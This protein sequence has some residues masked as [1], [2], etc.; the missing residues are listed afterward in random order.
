MPNPFHVGRLRAAVDVGGIEQVDSSFQGFV[1]DFKAGRLVGQFAEVHRAES[2]S[3]DLQAGAAKVRVLHRNISF[4]P[5]H[6][7]PRTAFRGNRKG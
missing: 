1:H 7:K 6:Y 3:A 2:D 5:D 4:A